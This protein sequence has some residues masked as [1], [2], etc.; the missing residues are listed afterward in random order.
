MQQSNIDPIYGTVIPKPVEV[1]V[2][3]FD[4]MVHHRDPATGRV[5]KSNPYRLHCQGNKQYF[6]RPINSGNLYWQNNQPAGRRM[7]N[8]QTAKWN[9]IE[10]AAH[11]AWI[12]PEQKAAEERQEL[13]AKVDRI[14]DMEAKMLLMEQR[15]IEAEAKAALKVAP[16]APAAPKQEVVTP[17]EVQAKPP[18]AAP[19][20]AVAKKA[21][22]TLQGLL[23]K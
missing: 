23:N 11:I 4:L 21:P 22:T 18:A 1:E 3:D 2:K 9:I 6:E 16:I 8:P 12:S 20:Q 7:L 10:G 15:A 14:E 17:V 5:T 13:L 19:K